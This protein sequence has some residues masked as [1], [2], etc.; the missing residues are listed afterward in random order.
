MNIDIFNPT[1]EHKSLRTMVNKFSKE[2]LFP[3]VIDRD[4]NE[5]FDKNIFKKM[6]E[7]GI[8]GI[9]APE[10][11][12]GSEMDCTSTIIAHEEISYYDPSTALAY[13]AHS[14]LCVN[15]I[16][17]NCDENQKKQFLPK[18]CSGEHIGAM[19]IS[20][21]DA[22]SD[23]MAMK[24]NAQKQN[25]SFNINGNKMW[26]TNG[27]VDSNNN[28]CD[29]LYL[30]AK[31]DNKLST[32][33]I[34]KGTKGFCVGQKIHGK[35]GM[36]GSSTAE[37]SFEN[38]NIPLSNEV[39]HESSVKDMMRNLQIE[40]LTL[41]AISVGIARYVIDVMISYSNERMAFNQPIRNF[42]QIQK[43]IA[44]SYAEYM[45]CKS[46][47]YNISYNIDLNAYNFRVECDSIKLIAATM[48][49]KAADLAVQVLGGNG[50]VGEYHVER[51]WRD[52]KLIEIGGGT[53][54]ALQKNIVKD[55]SR[56]IKN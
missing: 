25:N 41:A 44:D 32:Y 38:C 13:L 23:V 16:V 15:N 4:K 56:R 53:N 34:E 24:T 50:Y 27:V 40:R 3:G 7:L 19:A 33:L 22:G 48:A 30:Y 47:L 1:E 6:G 31:R 46:Y 54:E 45:A 42:G 20:E 43:Y 18:L 2:F 17:A 29:V 36:R 39:S 52:A 26:I 21:A 37:L 55:L 10:V 8:L 14:I 11:Y 9:T 51:F 12:G 5:S 49:K 35:L 28:T